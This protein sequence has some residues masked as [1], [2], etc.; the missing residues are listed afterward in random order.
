MTGVKTLSAEYDT[1]KKTTKSACKLKI[2]D[3]LGDVELERKFKLS[4]GELKIKQ[5]VP[6]GHFE[7]IPSPEFQVRW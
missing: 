6:G 1:V 3:G 2:T 7:L 4:S 5:K